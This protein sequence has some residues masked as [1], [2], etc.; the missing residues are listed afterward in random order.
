VTVVGA[1]RR[2]RWRRLLHRHRRTLAAALTFLAVLTAL[3]ALRHEAPA[4]ATA[5]FA[6][7]AGSACTA[8]WSSTSLPDG[9]LAAPVRLADAGVV[10][11]LHPGDV[12]DVV[13]A[14]SRGRGAVVAAAA[15]VLSVPEAASDP[16][17]TDPLGGALVVLAVPSSTGV[18]LAGAAAVG[19]LSLLLHS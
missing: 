3:S 2:R 8:G 13:A 14:D 18:A 6:C 11:L 7:S 19:P 4:P 12:V 17:G 15:T 16:L 10:G 5:S 9:L 1:D